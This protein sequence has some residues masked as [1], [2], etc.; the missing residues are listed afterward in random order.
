MVLSNLWAM[1]ADFGEKE[2]RVSESNGKAEVDKQ[3]KCLINNS[4]SYLNLYYALKVKTLYSLCAEKSSRTYK[5]L[6]DLHANL[7]ETMV[8]VHF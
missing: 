7:R 4:L 2:K 3:M 1:P 8:L 5:F 6:L